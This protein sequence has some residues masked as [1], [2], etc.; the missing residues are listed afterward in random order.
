MSFPTT[1]ENGWK[2]FELDC[3][4]RIVIVTVKPKMFRKLEEA[5]DNYPMWV[6]AISGKMDANPKQGFIL[7]KP[8]IQAF[9]RK[10]KPPKEA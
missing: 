9:E 5:R 10:P 6:A 8:S 2:Q 3:D 4:G 1:L 7:D